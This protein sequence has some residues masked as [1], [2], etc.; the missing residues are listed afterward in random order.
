MTA[1]ERIAILG[2]GCSGTLLATQ[3]LRRAQR[4]V[5]VTILEPRPI[6]GRGLA[7]DTRLACH[8]LNVPAGRLSAHVDQRNDFVEWLEA[9]A[10]APGAGA[11]LPR[12][13]Y[14]SYL[15]A[16]LTTARAEA[17]EGVRFEHLP[18]DVLDV[19]PDREAFEIVPAAGPTLRAD[20]VVLALGH[21]A[22]SALAALAPGRTEGP[23][24]VSNP[25]LPGATD[26]QQAEGDVLL[27]GSGLTAVDVILTLRHRGHEGRIV[28]VSRHGLLPLSH[29][30]P[31]A[32]RPI[33]TAPWPIEAR[34]TCRGLLR[35]LR[36]RLRAAAWRGSDWR[37]IVDGLRPQTQA[38]WRALGP[39]ERRRFVRHLQG[40]W[41][42]L[43]H[44]MAPDVAK[45]LA[46][47]VDSGSVRVL[48]GRVETLVDLPG[49]VRAGVRR[50]GASQ[51]DW[52]DVRHVVDC[53]GPG[54]IAGASEP[55]L[56][57]LFTRGLV[58]PDALGLGLDATPTGRLLSPLDPHGERLFALGPLLKGTLW[59][60]TAVPEIR[61]QAAG[62]AAR[63]L[64][65]GSA[66][67][68]F[69]P[70]RESTGVASGV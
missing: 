53:T 16:V 18:T 23:R 43:R 45:V 30:E 41:D 66:R 48:R 2:G 57:A 26:F 70:R 3:L 17:H 59:E 34:V 22:P 44:R 63:L 31:Q 1:P 58:R 24:Y 54:P 7:Y 55:L 42:V 37:P 27:L 67:A 20:R 38:L 49:G 50:R 35:E 60:T 6:L 13:L 52:L 14:A 10:N 39:A 46:R 8:L 40:Y 32:Q 25:W 11:F 62:L 9:H 65:L 33:T 47:A 19:R 56:R 51:C 21:R 28:A 36:E 4:P 29:L 15:D 12:G 5:H 61:E 68:A 64:A 69:A